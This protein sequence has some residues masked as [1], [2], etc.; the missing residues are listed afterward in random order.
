MSTAGTPG[1]VAIASTVVD[2]TSTGHPGTSLRRAT[3][4][5]A[6]ASGESVSRSIFRHGCATSPFAAGPGPESTAQCAR[7][8]FPFRLYS[9]F[10]H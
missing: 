7:L 8:R 10:H 6:T 1:P 4:P 2:P 3:L 9:S 5:E